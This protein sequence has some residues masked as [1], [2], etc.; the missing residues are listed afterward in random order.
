VSAT[1]PRE[2]RS[3]HFFVL[4]LVLAAGLIAWDHKF[5]FVDEH[6]E[7]GDAAANALQI[8]Q[9]KHLNELHGNYSRFKF[10][11]PGPG[12]F[13]GYAAGEWVLYDLLRVVPSPY[14]AHVFVGVLIQT[15]FF[16]WALAIVAR[17]VRRKL[18]VPLIVLF[19]ALHFGA[20]NYNIPHSMYE[21]IWP[22]HVLLFPF[23][24]FL[25]ACASLASGCPKHILPA[26]TAGSLLVHGHVAQPL[27]VVPLFAVSCA[28]FAIRLRVSGAT[29]GS[30]VRADRRSFI[31]AA[32][33]LFGF[34]LPLAI[35][36]FGG[37]K[38]NL[39]HIIA[40]FT[41]SSGDR[42][43]LLQSLNYL[44]NFLC[45]VP[46]PE[47]FCNVLGPES[48]LYARDRWY[49]V[50]GWLLLAALL[51]GASRRRAAAALPFTRW[52]HVHFG[53]AIVLMLYWGTAQTGEMFAFNSHF[54]YALLFV[55]LV[56]LAITTAGAIN[57][58]AALVGAP[59][60]LALAV[61]L[62][63]AS[64][65][66][67]RVWPQLSPGATFRELAAVA[68]AEPHRK[69]FLNFPDYEWPWAVGA[70]LALRRL[71]L[72]Y[73]VRSEWGIMFGDDKTANF[74]R[75]LRSN[76]FAIWDFGVD[77]AKRHG[78]QLVGGPFVGTLPPK[79]APGT[80]IL[81]A[82]EAQNAAT[83]AP[84]GWDLSSG[85]FSFSVEKAAI[86][87]FQPERAAGDVEMTVDAFPALFGSLR[88]QRMLVSING[89]PLEDVTL[90]SGAELKIII[91]TAAWNGAPTASIV[92]DFPTSTSPAHLG[93]SADPRRLGYGFR[94]IS[95]RELPPSGDE[96]A[97]R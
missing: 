41:G 15:G 91:P 14:N 65:Y 16:A 18:V 82:T 44:G 31:G 9:A 63:V 37:S 69:K 59:A 45:Y 62:F 56:S 93:V 85:E 49:V 79:L 6:W 55:P 76:R 72:D 64:S 60:A 8:R 2:F 3:W 4:W 97:T 74:A 39:A 80:E 20:V 28:A 61:P 25:V 29:I 68:K 11:H 96:S 58:R 36:A 83:W 57:D 33:V 90:S 94:R 50:A 23:L 19:A 51:I 22:P 88:Q 26:I 92:F 34:V 54:A 70:A 47:K 27:F 48:L 40:H 67:W 87:Y 38:S 12:F 10:H 32:I 89:R 86:L 53:I 75:T 43:T 46:D 35:D 95:F 73:R 7:V 13:Y 30:V 52:V 24:C 78:F 1:A 71:G 66:D 42:K 21:S 77:P 81:F 17:H 84:H 5:Y